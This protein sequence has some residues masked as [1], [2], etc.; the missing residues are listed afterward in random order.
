M[1]K[2]SKHNCILNQN[3]KEYYIIIVGIIFNGNA[4]GKSFCAVAVITV[5]DEFKQ[6]LTKLLTLSVI[7]GIIIIKV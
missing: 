4:G 6:K 1:E 7:Y 3:K 5:I 2:M